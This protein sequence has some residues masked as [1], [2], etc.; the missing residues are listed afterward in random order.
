MDMVART[1]EV[2]GAIPDGEERNLSAALVLLLGAK[3]MY[4]G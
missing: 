2:A 3:K 1:A 4:C